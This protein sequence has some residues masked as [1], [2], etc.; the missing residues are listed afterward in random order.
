M[1]KNHEPDNA[2]QA[3]CVG[4][5]IAILFFLACAIIFHL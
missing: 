5:L 3:A 2:I 4:A 1:K